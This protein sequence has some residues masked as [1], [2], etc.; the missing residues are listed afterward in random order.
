MSVKVTLPDGSV[1]EV[2]DGSTA[3]DVATSISRG[4]AKVSV[5]AKVNG[6]V[7]DFH[8]PL[9]AECTVN[10]IKEDSAE[11]LE[12]IRHS[13]AHVM[14][15]A[16]Q[17]VYGKEVKFGYG[18]A[19]EDGF[20]YDMQFPEGVKFSESDLPKIE[21][22]CKKIIEANYPFERQDLPKAEVVGKMEALGQPF[23]VQTLQD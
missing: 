2:P 19:I 17:R 5:A 1:R 21:A 6:E 14:A 13:A 7:W 16:V 10:I 15:G 8:R 11:G 23:K 12:V 18:P 20:Y 4:L 3:L 9:P 22:E